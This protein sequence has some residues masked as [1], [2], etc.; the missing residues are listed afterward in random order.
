M[1]EAPSVR[2]GIDPRGPRF[3]AG[4]TAVLLLV[5]VFLGLTG[6][7]TSRAF[8]WFAYQPLAEATLTA[9]GG[10]AIT[11]ATVGERILDPAFLLLLV[12]ALLFLWGVLSP[13]TAPW[14]AL[15]RSL[16][17][18]RLSPPVD[19]EDPR[20]PRFAQG[21]GLFVTTLGLVLHLFG[22]PWALVV[23]AA[24][25]FVAAFLNAVFGLCLGCQ[26]YLLL[27]RAGI[28]G[29]ERPAAA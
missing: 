14:G 10:W 19:L 9:G 25:A 12:I 18:P 15:Y 24:L 6:L 20:P 26:L 4:I 21:V 7:S 29:R 23:A 5:D 8:G 2:G 27:Q 22:V 1:S 3:V 16:I 17:A 11:A 13:R 28:V